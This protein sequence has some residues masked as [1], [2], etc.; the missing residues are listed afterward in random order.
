MRVTDAHPSAS[1]CGPTRRAL[2][3]GRYP[4]R[5]AGTR[6]GGPWGFVGPKP[7]T[8]NSTLGKLLKRSGYRTGYVGQSQSKCR[9]A[10]DQNPYQ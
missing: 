10:V 4:W 3:T 6:N 7:N 8:E 5:F 1:I 9:S 2:M